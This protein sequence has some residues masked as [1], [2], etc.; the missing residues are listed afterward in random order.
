MFK[1]ISNYVLIFDKM[2]DKLFKLYFLIHAPINCFVGK[3]WF[4]PL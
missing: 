2:F 3:I 1:N 4:W